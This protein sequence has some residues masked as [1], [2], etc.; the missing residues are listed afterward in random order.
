MKQTDIQGEEETEN[1]DRQTG[2]ERERETEIE[3]HTRDKLTQCGCCF[4]V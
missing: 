4:D 1:E 3:R 2:R